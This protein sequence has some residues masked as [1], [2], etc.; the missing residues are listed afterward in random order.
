MID[1]GVLLTSSGRSLGV[2]PMPLILALRGSG[3]RF[4]PSGIPPYPENA[5]RASEAFWP[6]PS[7]GYVTKFS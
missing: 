7:N 5:S 4:P 6:F 1:D 2:S 3:C